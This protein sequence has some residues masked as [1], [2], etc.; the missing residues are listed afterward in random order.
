MAGGRAGGAEDEVSPGQTKIEERYF[1]KTHSKTNLFRREVMFVKRLET[2]SGRGA[3]S[4]TSR[5]QSAG[6][7]FRIN[8]VRDRPPEKGSDSESERHVTS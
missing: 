4:V 6:T 5:R 1:V 3:Q 7:R 8:I 2:R